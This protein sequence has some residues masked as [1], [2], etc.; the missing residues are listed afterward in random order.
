MRQLLIFIHIFFLLI[1]LHLF[2]QIEPT[3]QNLLLKIPENSIHQLRLMGERYGV[4]VR[5]RTANF[6]IIQASRSALPELRNPQILDSIIPDFNYYILWLDT[7][8]RLS[9]IEKY[10]IVLDQFDQFYLIKLHADYESLLFRFPAHHRAKLP[11]EIRL[12]KFDQPAFAPSLATSPQQQTIIQEL[13][14]EVDVNRWLAEIRNLVEN[15]DLEQPGK[16]FRS[17]YSFRVREAVQFDG[18]PNP[19]HACDNAADYIA[20]QFRRYG[21]QV[22]FDPFLHRRSRIGAG[23]VGEYT[24]RNVVATLPGKGPN[25]DRVYLMVGHYDSI[26]TKTAGWEQNWR[27]L[28]APGASDNASGVAAML[29]TARILSKHDFDFTIRFIAFSGEE[30]FLFGSKH[31]RD[32]VKARGDQIAG[33]LNFDLLGHDEDGILD[34]HVLGDDQS[35]WLVNA[36]GTAAERYNIDVD[37]RKKNDPSFIFSDHS[38]FWEVGIPAVMVAE[39]SSFNAPESTDYVHSEADTLA[40]ITPPLGE[41]AV[42][43]AVA[44]LSELARPIT[45]PD[46][47]DQVAPDILWDSAGISISNPTITKDET[48]GLSATVK[49]GGPVAVKGIIVQF[50]AVHPDGVT[51]VIAEQRVDLDVAQSQTVNATFTPRMWGQFT[52]RAVANS[53]TNVFESDFGN[54]QIET[55]LIVSGRGVMIENIVTYPNPINFSQRS[56]PLKLTYILS[57]DADVEISIYTMLGEKIFENEFLAGENGGRLGANNAFSWKGRNAHDEKVA[58]GIYICQVTATDMENKSE[59]A[60]TKVAVIWR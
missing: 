55:A 25:K 15:Q 12:S 60:E 27:T 29:E 56:D 59:T 28:P 42:K 58:S 53:D 9:E 8:E 57:R 39:E 23:L 1:T 47:T 34:I 11:P 24:M 44:T 3:E 26:S 18:K 49:N 7:P 31:Y 48:V 17:R 4:K 36:F 43:L 52:L 37:L 2:A 32:G 41:L 22:E 50:V 33:V 51:E 10:G 45:T 16:F 46:Q 21:L 40:K 19:D 13:L 14:D 54:N 6:S 30:L 5:Y 38:P 20:E 35:Q